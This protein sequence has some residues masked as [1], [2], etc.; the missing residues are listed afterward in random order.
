M[1]GFAG[2]ELQLRLLAA[3]LLMQGVLWGLARAL[4]WR[5]RPEAI[6]AGLLLPW[7]WLWPWIAGSTLLVPTGALVHTLPGTLH[8]ERQDPW[9]ELHDVVSQNL[10][11]ET[12]V[13]HALARGRLPFWS[14]AL[15]GGSSPWSN[16]MAGTLSPIAMLTRALPLQH[17]TLAALAI[18]MLVALQGA[19]VLARGLGARRFSALL[20]GVS[21]AG[22]GAIM[23]WGLFPQSNVAAWSPWLVAGAL[24]LARRPRAGA[25]IATAAAFA[26]LLL[27]GNPEVALG[28]GL[29]AAVVALT[30]LRRRVWRRA[31]VTLVLAA[32]A[33]AALAAP[34]LA[35]FISLLPRTERAQETIERS[36]P[37]GQAKLLQ[38]GSWFWAWQGGYLLSP[39]NPQAFGRPFREAFDGPIGWTNALTPYAGLL[40]CAGVA[41]ALAT[42]RRRRSA[43]ALL[44]FALT[45]LLLAAGFLPLLRLVLAAPLLR[46]PEYSRLLHA[47]ALAL[48]VAGALGWDALYRRRLSASRAVVAIALAATVSLLVAPRPEIVALWIGLTLAALSLALGRRRVGL[49]ALAAVLVMRSRTLGA[50]AAAAR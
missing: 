25:L 9:V 10:P 39:A 24:R 8:L 37:T 21:F 26:A 28:A 46:L 16:P 7:V 35:P 40:A 45:A 11:W 44:G 17:F 13:R 48:A 14:D 4:G 3:L 20:A 32:F 23:A 18:K 2:W 34:M 1:G 29:L 5:L 49:G 19:W 33:G 42:P 15:D 31:L 12:E 30:H 41:L 36:V 50:L 27:S 38:P 6:F 47:V 22:S 43:V